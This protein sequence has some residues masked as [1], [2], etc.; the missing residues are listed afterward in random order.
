MGVKTEK[1]GDAMTDLEQIVQVVD[2]Y[3]DQLVQANDKIWGYAELAYEESKSAEL[4]CD[5]LTA[6]GFAVVKG[7]AGMPTSF[8]ATFVNGTGKPVAG[9]LGEYDALA[10]L[11]QKAG[12]TVKDPVNEG[13]PGH[14]C[15]HC[16]LGTGALG[17]ALA[18]KEYLVNNQK[19]GT[20]I[21]YGCA[22]EEG[23]G[24]KQ[25]MAR[26]GLFDDVDFVYTWHPATRNEV[27]ARP[28]VAIM[29]A[30]F[31]FHGITA[32][33]GGSPHLGRSALD[34]AELMSVGVNYLR[35]HMIDKARIHYAYVDAGGTA[36]NVVQ[37]HSLVK[38]EVR[39]PKVAQMKELF[40]R[41]VD[42]ARGS[43]LMTGT[44]MEYEITMAFSDYVPNGTLAKMAVDCLAEVGAP[45][46]DEEDYRLAKAYLDS[47]DPVTRQGILEG[48]E[49]EYAPAELEA[50]LARPL[51]DTVHPYNPYDNEYESGST[52]VGDVGY[53][54]PTLEMHVATACIGNVG[55]TWQMTAQAGSQ[56]GHKGLLVAAKALALSVIRTMESPETIA[57]AKEEFVRRTGGVYH[58]PLPDEVEPPIGRY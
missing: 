44:K 52:D 14:G 16:C 21:Y 10:T 12:C 45:K 46:W 40:E 32:H 24:A 30:N 55:H 11:S 18:V 19:D 1:R 36:P 9:I 27:S 39:A 49:E 57:A 13:A 22:A 29:G 2:R 7:V 43:A 8:T 54:A 3:A 42:V 26:A 17:A 37:D 6:E 28:S 20:V 41:V 35:E 23:A 53:A 25:F 48:L 5:I 34:A 38:Y 33:A 58:C 56:L 4:L 31:Q 15:G 50:V 51:D 47:Y